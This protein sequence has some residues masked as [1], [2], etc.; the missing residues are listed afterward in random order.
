MVG[1]TVFTR[2]LRT[3]C[4]S[5]SWYKTRVQYHH[6]NKSDRYAALCILPDAAIST[7]E[8]WLMRKFEYNAM[9]EKIP[10]AE[11]AKCWEM[12]R[13]CRQKVF[14]I[15]KEFDMQTTE[16]ESFMNNK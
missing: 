7:D 2:A 14:N 4:S 11:K 5:P 9:F 6:V 16:L 10:D 1:A 12:F 3:S 13:D 15:Q 8:F